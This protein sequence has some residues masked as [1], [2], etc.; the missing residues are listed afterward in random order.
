MWV[1][2]RRGG[3]EGLVGVGGGCGGLCCCHLCIGT[4]GAGSGVRG[5][6]GVLPTTRSSPPTPAL[7]RQPT[8]SPSAAREFRNAASGALAHALIVA[9]DA[10]GAALWLPT[11]AAP[12]GPAPR[13]PPLQRRRVIATPF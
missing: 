10:L 4:C 1:G 12:A 7:A 11:C 9:S 2:A 8:R 5:Q 3:G 6:E 13:R